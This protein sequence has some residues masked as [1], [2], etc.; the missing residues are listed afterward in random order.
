MTHVITPLTNLEDI[1]S[2]LGQALGQNPLIPFDPLMPFDNFGT[3]PEISQNTTKPPK[4]KNVQNVEAHKFVVD[5]H[6]KFG[7]I[8]GETCLGRCPAR[9]LGQNP[10]KS[11]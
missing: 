5:W 10:Y 3:F 11:L 6:L 7:G 2:T 8:L 4:G 1:R 9:I